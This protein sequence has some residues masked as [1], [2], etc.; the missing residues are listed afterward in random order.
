MAS[1]FLAS[2]SPRR[3]ALLQQIGIHPVVHAVSIDESVLPG[4]TPAAYVERLARAKVLAAA[5]DIARPSA[6][7]L[8]ADTTVSAAGEIL[9]KPTD[10]SDACRIWSLLPSPDHCVLTGVAL[11]HDGQVETR[12]VSTAVSFRPI[13]EEDRLAYWQSGE[14]AD[15]AGGYAIQGRAALYVKAIHGCYSNVVGLPLSETAELLARHQFPF[16]E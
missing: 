5:S 6:Y 12:V 11:W 9:G 4:E 13:P 14:P 2:S 8:A 3:L 15:K 1:L 10:Y 7:V 16:R